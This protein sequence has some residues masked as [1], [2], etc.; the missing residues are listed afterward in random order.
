MKITF[1]K[2][3]MLMTVR[4]PLILDHLLEL[5]A[6]FAKEKC[7]IYMLCLSGAVELVTVRM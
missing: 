4:Q 2:L 7:R 5:K 3:D 6:M 1:V